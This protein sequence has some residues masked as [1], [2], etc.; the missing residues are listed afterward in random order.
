MLVIKERKNLGLDFK[1]Y[2]TCEHRSLQTL[3]LLL[4]EHYVFTFINMNEAPMKLRPSLNKKG[5]SR[6]S[7]FQGKW[8]SVREIAGQHGLGTSFC[9]GN[10]QPYCFIVWRTLLPVQTL[11]LLPWTSN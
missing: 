4:L 7:C 11:P 6:Q 9:M 8:Y 3:R 10:L 1:V 2:I 5:P